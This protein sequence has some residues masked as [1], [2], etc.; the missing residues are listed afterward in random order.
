MKFRVKVFPTMISLRCEEKRGE[1]PTHLGSG[2]TAGVG[3]GALWNHF[4]V[5]GLKAKVWLS[6]VQL[7]RG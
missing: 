2:S 7:W 1:L 6:K 3:L 5:Q 4:V